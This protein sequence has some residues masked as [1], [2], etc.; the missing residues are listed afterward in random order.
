MVWSSNLAETLEI[1]VKRPQRPIDMAHL[2]KQALG[3]WGIEVEVLRMF[4]E[5]I[6]IYFGRLE[7]SET[8]PELTMNLHTINGAAAGIGAWTLRDLAKTAEDEVREGKAVNPE[9]IDDIGMAVEEVRSFIAR[10][11]RDE[12][13]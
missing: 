11:L 10:L 9:R 13:L 5:M 4:D 8:V 7:T 2:A 1:A 6:Q 12:P 3:D